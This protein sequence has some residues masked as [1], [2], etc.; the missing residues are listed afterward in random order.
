M[1]ISLRDART[2]QID[3]LLSSCRVWKKRH[4]SQQSLDTVTYLS[5]LVPICAEIGVDISSAAQNAVADVLWAQGEFSTAVSMLQQVV[6]GPKLKDASEE[7][8]RASLLAKLVSPLLF[9][10]RW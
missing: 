6:D 8:Q 10:M 4:G 3:A 9:N 1:H 7:V 5:D 2:L